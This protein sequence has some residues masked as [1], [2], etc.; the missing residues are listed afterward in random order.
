MGKKRRRTTR[1]GR[2]LAQS[3]TEMLAHMD[4]KVACQVFA[5]D[6]PR[7]IRRA[8]G[9]TPSEMAQRLRMHPE[10]Y[11]AW[12]DG[13]VEVVNEMQFWRPPRTKSP[14]ERLRELVEAVQ[15]GNRGAQADAS[16]PKRSASSTPVRRLRSK[17]RSRG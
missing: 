7:E 11:L 5:Y 8:A 17:R 4:G 9:L 13:L 12:E 2:E 15:A 1:F 16:G 10:A 6:R 3:V 14:P